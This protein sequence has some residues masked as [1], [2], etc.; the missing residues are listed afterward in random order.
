MLLFL[1]QQKTTPKI[2]TTNSEDL[3]G[4]KTYDLFNVSVVWWFLFIFTLFLK[5]NL[6]KKQKDIHVLVF[7][8]HY[9]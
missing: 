7:H 4:G 5:L 9:F 1:C 8:F 2:S 6:E 3:G